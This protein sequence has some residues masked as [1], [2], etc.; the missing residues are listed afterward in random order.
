MCSGGSKKRPLCETSVLFSFQ[1]PLPIQQVPFVQRTSSCT[2]DSNGRGGHLFELNGSY[3]V[4]CEG[5]SVPVAAAEF[6]IY[7][8]VALIY[9]LPQPQDAVYKHFIYGRKFEWRTPRAWPSVSGQVSANQPATCLPIWAMQMRE[10]SS[11]AADAAVAE[12]PPAVSFKSRGDVLLQAN[13]VPHTGN[14]SSRPRKFFKG[15]RRGAVRLHS[16]IRLLQKICFVIARKQ[17]IAVISGDILILITTTS[18]TFEN[19]AHVTRTAKFP[20]DTSLKN[21]Y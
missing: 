16:L 17:L 21:S 8:R 5:I 14:R 12:S 3:T 19:K 7:P 4:V 11:F 9:A 6:L 1:G 13:A 18:D 20:G 15:Q 2:P 10:R